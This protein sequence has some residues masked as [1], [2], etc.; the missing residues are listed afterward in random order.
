MFPLHFS[1]AL[2]VHSHISWGAGIREQPLL[3]TATPTMHCTL[4][5]MISV[6]IFNLKNLEQRVRAPCIGYMRF[7][8]NVSW[9]KTPSCSLLVSLTVQR[10]NVGVCLTFI[11]PCAC[12]LSCWRSF[13]LHHF[14]GKDMEIS[15]WKWMDFIW[16]AL[17]QYSL[18]VGRSSKPECVQP[19]N[20]CAVRL[21]H[22]NVYF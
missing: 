22:G 12:L 19:V 15:L 17:K 2:V 14:P 1:D 6:F 18:W 8:K 16:N 11:G 3:R 9:W 21:K 20:G 5:L 4:I 7:E 10:P 13:K